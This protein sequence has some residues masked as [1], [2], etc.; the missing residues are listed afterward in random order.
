MIAGKMPTVCFKLLGSVERNFQ[1]M[2][3][4]PLI[5]IYI[6]IAASKAVVT[7]AQKYIKNFKTKSF[8]RN[9]RLVFVMLFINTLTPVLQ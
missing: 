1:L 5:K 3:G 6:K 4:M 9:F 2:L 7:A 8:G